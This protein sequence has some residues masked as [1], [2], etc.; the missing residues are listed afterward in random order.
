MCFISFGFLLA[1]ICVWV[2]M[3][4]SLHSVTTGSR[5]R[6]NVSLIIIIRY[7]LPAVSYYLPVLIN[8][9]KF[10]R[11]RKKRAYRVQTI[12]LAY[13]HLL[14]G[15]I[16]HTSTRPI[17]S[18]SCNYP[19]SQGK[20]YILQVYYRWELGRK[21]TKKVLRGMDPNHDVRFSHPRT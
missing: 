10:S 6:A 8:C 5:D 7:H 3:V 21:G 16:H 15:Q 11:R 17:V 20:Y 1:T 19:P 13:L 12:F 4:C 18:R 2:W 14:C 9:S